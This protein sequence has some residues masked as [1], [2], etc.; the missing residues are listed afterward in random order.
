MKLA[1]LD[2]NHILKS[3]KEVGPDDHRTSKDDLTVA[4]PPNSDI[5]QFPDKY[6]YNYDIG[7]FLPV[8]NV[9]RFGTKLMDYNTDIVDALV[10]AV[11]DLIDGKK[12]NLPE[13]LL[14]TLRD[15]KVSLGKKK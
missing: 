7:S 4:L 9:E 12:P 6:Y 5:D 1:I 13:G 2:E 14:V 10:I 11:I 3:V 8:T 15:R